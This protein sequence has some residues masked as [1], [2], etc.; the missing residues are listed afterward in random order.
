[1]TRSSADAFV[2]ARRQAER[3]GA[4]DRELRPLGDSVTFIARNV[5]NFRAM[6]QVRAAMALAL[7]DPLGARALFATRLSQDSLAT[8]KLFRADVRRF[9]DSL[10]RTTP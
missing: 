9:V 5:D 6:Y 3:L 7:V 1:M 10:A 8:Q 4:T 2:R